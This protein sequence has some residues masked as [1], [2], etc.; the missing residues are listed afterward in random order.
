[1]PGKLNPHVAGHNVSDE[2]SNIVTRLYLKRKL[3]LND[4]KTRRQEEDIIRQVRI[5]FL[6]VALCATLL[7]ALSGVMVYY[8]TNSLT[9]EV[10][11][12][13]CGSDVISFALNILIEYAKMSMREERCILLLD[14]L[15]GFVSCML[16]LCVAF[17]GVLD[18]MSRANFASENMGS[19]RVVHQDLMLFYNF[20]CLTLDILAVAFLFRL[21]EMMNPGGRSGRDQ[22]NVTSGVMHTVVDFL[23]TMFV[24]GTTFWMFY[25]SSKHETPWAEFS[26]KVNGD[27]FGSFLLCA[28]V[29]LS[30]AFL[31]RESLKTLM[32]IYTTGVS[33][34]AYQV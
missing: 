28:C 1:M 8:A 6:F 4:A 9:V 20:F 24:T 17:F 12:L 26:Q 30:A 2:A 7:P 14:F 10:D 25:V 5:R 15:G 33:N 16:L 31:I 19:N 29:V 13:S 3:Q 21:R 27:V 11:F 18:A 23:R 32:K 34:K 22:L